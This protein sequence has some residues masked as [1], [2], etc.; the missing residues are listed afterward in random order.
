MILYTVGQIEQKEDL[1]S[2]PRSHMQTVL[3]PPPY[4]YVYLLIDPIGAYLI[5]PSIFLSQAISPS[6]SIW[7]DTGVMDRGLHSNYSISLITLS[8]VGRPINALIQ[9]DPRHFDC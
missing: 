1:F 4:L 6:L 7:A 9:M 3:V 8:Q 2:P 5:S